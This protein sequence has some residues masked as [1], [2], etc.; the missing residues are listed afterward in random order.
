MRALACA[1]L[2]AAAM[3]VVAHAAEPEWVGSR[4]GI[5]DELPAP[6]TPVVAEGGSLTCWGREYDFGAGALPARVVTA[7]EQVLADAIRVRVTAGGTEQVWRPAQL[8]WTDLRPIAASGQVRATAELA[9]LQTDITLEFDGMMRIDLTV[10]PAEGVALDEVVLEVPIKPAHSTY[11]HACDA[12]WGRSV[13][14]ALPVDGWAHDFMPFVWLGDEDR[15]LQWFCESDEGWRPSDPQRVLTIDR[16]GERVVLRANMLQRPLDAGQTFRTTFG[17]QA[18]PVKPI[19][20]EHRDWHITHGASYGM[21]HRSTDIALGVNYPAPEHIR[22]DRGSV[23]MWVKPLFDPRAGDTIGDKLVPNH[24]LFGVT[25][26]NGDHWGFYWNRDDRGTR[27][28]ARVNGKVEGY[29]AH[30]RVDNWRQ[31]Q[32]RH[33]AFTWGDRLCIYL[34]GELI[35][36]KDWSGTM[37]GDLE[38]AKIWLGAGGAFRDTCRFDVDNLRVGATPLDFT[39][40]ALLGRVPAA[41]A[42]TLLLDRFDD[43]RSGS[44][45]PR[46]AALV[47]GVTGKALRLGRRDDGSGLLDYLKRVGVNTL[48]FHENWTEIQA[49]GST[50]LHD[51]DLRE[52][53]AACHAADIKLLLYFGYLFSDIAP[54]WA[55]YSDQ[56][57]SMPRR[58]GYRRKDFPQTAYISCPGS[59]WNEYLLTSIARMIDEYDIDGVYLDGTT[60][61]WGCANELHGCGYVGE[62]GKRH[63]TYPIFATRDLMRRM[64]QIVK[65]RKPDGLIS[66]HMSA[67]VT[68][69]TLAFVDDYWD[70]EQL[71]VKERGFRLPLDAFRAEFMG[72]NYGLPAEFLSY[73]NKPFTFEEAL[74]LALLHDVPVRPGVLGRKLEV[75]SR[76]WAVWDEFGVDAAR[77]VPYWQEGGPLAA[78]DPDILISAHV[79]E[80]G[81]LAVVMN[82]AQEDR[83]FV[84]TL[85]R[86]NVSARDVLTDEEVVFDSGVAQM[87]LAPLHMRMLLI[88]RK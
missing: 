35:A 62:D 67:S 81:I 68:M 9:E 86:E 84:L 44:D 26:A 46:G 21:Q 42:D 37:A 77:W 48:V 53:V 15:G 27:F 79:G 38:G 25:L 65:S 41:T 63:R 36:S 24:S 73:E 17:L 4:I 13:A 59:I 28:Y 32:W 18:T 5:S 31:G 51:Q 74:G 85:A 34:D 11:L 70:G 88:S 55:A 19:P 12:S 23:D 82:S 49:Y 43:E 7:N 72:R 64:R 45:I 75:M 10:T 60:E 78:N 57:L 83:E 40:P 47:A 1:M 8:R 16:E 14:M 71:D 52:L 66:A 29:L 76:I 2:A 20:A 87:K 69:P 30:D 39:D 50:K 33:V 56:V 3:C 6:W 22:L 61:P 54:E 58:G 80:N